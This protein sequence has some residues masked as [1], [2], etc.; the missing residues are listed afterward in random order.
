MK[1]YTRDQIEKKLKI[2]L[3]KKNYLVTYHPVTLNHES[4]IKHFKELL[5]FLNLESES[6]IIFT[7]PNADPNNKAIRKLIS[8]FVANNQSRSAHFTNLGQL[9]YISLMK[10]VDAV[11]GNS[12]SGILGSFNENSTINIGDRQ[13]G[14]IK[15]KSV[16]DCEPNRNSIKKAFKT[17]SSAKF[18]TNPL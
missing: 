9:K 3:L 11:V 2:K 6:F 1:I 12:S 13:E 18:C 10:H 4:S 14:R 16:I 7:M 17:L 8:E 5:N 15:A